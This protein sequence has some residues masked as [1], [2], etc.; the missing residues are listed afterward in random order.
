[1]N[2]K[3]SITV[4]ALSITL[5]FA[6]AAYAQPDAGELSIVGSWEA[7][8]R[9]NRNETSI[10]LTFSINDG[11]LQATLTSDGLGVYGLPADTVTRDGLRLTSTFTRL[12]AEISGWLRLD[13]AKSEVIRIDADWFQSAELVPIVLMPL[14]SN[15]N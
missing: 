13:D 7:P 9:I 2:S 1:M 5:A 8:I 11:E 6:A 4:I 15:S 10:A 14:S 3:T 12:G